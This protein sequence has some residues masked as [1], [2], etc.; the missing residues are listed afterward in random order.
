MTMRFLLG[1]AAFVLTATPSLAQVAAPAQC[2]F[3]PAPAI[4]DGAAATNTS[5]RQAREALD[6]W[7][8]TRANELAACQAATQVL[9]AQ[10]QAGASAYNAGLA[11]TNAAIDRFA[12]ENAEYTARGT[13]AGRRDRAGG[14]S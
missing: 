8:T 9:Q 11:E 4:P 3:T 6:A 13:V 10:A 2:S 14:A 7:R 12:A 5:M 1:A